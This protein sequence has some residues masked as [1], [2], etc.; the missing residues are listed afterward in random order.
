MRKLHLKAVP[1][2]EGARR[3]A[4]WVITLPGGVAQAAEALEISEEWV[5]RI[6]DG[7]LVPGLRIGT[8]LSTL[9]GVTAAMFQR[10]AR[11]GWFD[12]VPEAL[13]A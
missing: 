1:S 6:V 4:Q 11:T 2:S 3:V 12:R 9:M 13:A 7:D 10:A 5:Q 8:R